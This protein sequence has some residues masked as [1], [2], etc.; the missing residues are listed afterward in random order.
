MWRNKNLSYKLLVGSWRMYEFLYISSNMTMGVNLFGIDL[1][2][3]IIPIYKDWVLV[4]V[5]ENDV[6]KNVC[7]YV[8]LDFSKCDR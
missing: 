8:E 2:G 5:T 7:C 3:F 6:W 4:R 1:L